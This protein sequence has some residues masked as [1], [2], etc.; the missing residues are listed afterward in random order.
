MGGHFH[1]VG[2]GCPALGVNRDVALAV[3]AFPN[4]LASHVED[5]HT[6]DVFRGDVQHIGGGVGINADEDGLVLFHTIG[7]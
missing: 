5:F 4:A 2:A 1:H 6:V 3:L 7:Y